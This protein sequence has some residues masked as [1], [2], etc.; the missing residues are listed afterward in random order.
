M[1]GEWDFVA[2]L[3]LR[4]HDQ[5]ARGRHRQDLA[6][7]RRAPDADDGRVRG[8][9]APRPGGAVLGRSVTDRPA[10]RP[11]SDRPSRRAPCGGQRRV[12]RGGHRV[13]GVRRDS[14]SGRRRRAVRATA[15]RSSSAVDRRR[16][17][18]RR[19]A[20]PRARSRR[21]RTSPPATAPTAVVA[22]TGRPWYIASLQT[23]PH[24]S[25]KRGV[26]IEGSSAN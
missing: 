3:R 21:R 25:R 11:L 18:A 1:T 24:G 23:R 13:V 15:R 12:E 22:I 16:E 20:R 17:R 5:L 7:R 4:D 26:G 14:V 6:A 19:P 9:L 2:I 8:L 10:G